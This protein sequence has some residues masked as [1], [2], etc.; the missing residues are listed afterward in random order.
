MRTCSRCRARASSP[1]SCP[2]VPRSAPLRRYV[3]A[4]DDRQLA[5]RHRGGCARSRLVAGRFRDGDRAR[6]RQ[7]PRSARVP[8]RHGAARGERLL[9]QS[10][11]VARWP[12]RRVHGASA[13]DSTIAAGS[14]SS[15]AAGKVT[16][17]TG[18]LFGLQGL[19]WTPDGSTSC[20]RATPPARRCCSR[21]PCRHRDARPPSRSSPR[22]AG[23]S[24]STSRAM[25]DGWRCARIC[26]S[27]CAPVVPGQETERDL[28]WLGSTGARALSADGGWLLMVDVGIRGGR[29]YGVVLRKTDASQAIRLG[30]GQRPEALTRR[31]V[32]RRDHPGAGAGRDLSHRRR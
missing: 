13:C 29:N 30:E 2:A 24:C 27:A 23:S 11:R 25:G 9:E 14:R 10:S 20:S 12:P 31:Q 5:A 7:R 1:S 8:G 22:P 15:I 26:R 16:T 28:S 19:A 3:G 6:P 32:G 17:L 18:E 21:W 4:H